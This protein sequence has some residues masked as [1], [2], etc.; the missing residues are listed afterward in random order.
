MPPPPAPLAPASHPRVSSRFLLYV[1]IKLDLCG[2]MYEK[3]T[4]DMFD[5]IVQGHEVVVDEIHVNA[6]FS[7]NL[8]LERAAV[9]FPPK[10]SDVF[11]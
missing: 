10:S 2:G 6:P 4:D 11:K 9:V 7:G 1:R 8:S 5:R 3:F